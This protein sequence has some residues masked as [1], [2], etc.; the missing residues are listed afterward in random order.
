[1]TDHV[2]KRHQFGISLRKDEHGVCLHFYFVWDETFYEEFKNL[3]IFA[4][5]FQFNEIGALARASMYKGAEGATTRAERTWLLKKITI[6]R[7]VLRTGKLQL[8][9]LFG[10]TLS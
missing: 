7:I 6:S 8:S 9:P 4:L 1:M 10:R 5:H 2:V 3:I